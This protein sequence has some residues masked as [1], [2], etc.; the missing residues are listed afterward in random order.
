MAGRGG[1]RNNAGRKTGS[2]SRLPI[3]EFMTLENIYKCITKAMELVE[4]VQVEKK[5]SKGKSIVYQTPPNAYMIKAILDQYF[6]TPEKAF[7]VNPQNNNTDNSININVYNF[8]QQNLNNG[9]SLLTLPPK[10]VKS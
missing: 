3:T 6:G 9:N 1:K 8:T 10:Q 2:L 4:G 5:N 7:L